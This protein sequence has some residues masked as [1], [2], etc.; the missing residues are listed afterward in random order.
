RVSVLLA[1][2]SEL[3]IG[4]D[5]GLFEY[6]GNRFTR[7]LNNAS[8]AD[9]NRI[10]A[11][12]QRDSRLYIGTQDKGLYVWKEAHMEHLGTTEGLPSPH[13]TGLAEMPA[14]PEAG[15][16]A[17]SIIVATDF[18]VIGLTDENNVK[19]LSSRPNV[20][21][22]AVSGGHLWAGLFG[23]GIIDLSAERSK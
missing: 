3:L 4:T 8:G 17:G 5:G 7:R 14:S 23:G 6:D 21:S 9:F 18:G 12:L 15:S 10:T 1:T 11:L 2:E 13:V 16:F 19:A 20:T 22:L